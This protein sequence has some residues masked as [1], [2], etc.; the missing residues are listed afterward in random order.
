MKYDTPMSLQAIPVVRLATLLVV[1]TLSLPA[2]F[3]A[4]E[5]TCL[6][7]SGGAARGA[8]HVGVLEALEQL[9]VPVDCIVGTSM[10]AI[11]GGLYASGMT[12]AEIR[13]ELLSADWSDLFNDR[14]ARETIPFRRK[15]ND[16]L[17]LF[18]FEFGVNRSGLVFPSGLIA[19]QKLDFLLK[20]LTIHT[21]GVESFD[22]LPIR[23]R[24]VATSLV[25]GRMVVLDHGSLADALRASMSVPGV[26]SPIEIEGEFL[27]DGG[28]ARNLPV[29]VART[30]GADRVIA[31]DISTPVDPRRRPESAL[32]VVSR[33]TNMLM[34]QNME[35]QRR[36]IGEGDILIRP[37]LPG[38]GRSDFQRAGE[39][40]DLGRQAVLNLKEELAAFQVGSEP[41]E[42]WR[43]S[44]RDRARAGE[45]PLH[46]EVVL[47]E[48][49][50]RIDPRR[51]LSRV[52]TRPGKTVDLD[53][54]RQ[55]LSR[56]FELGDFERV[57]FRMEQG[58][59]G[60]RLILEAL[61]K[62]WGPNFVRFGLEL[63]A[64]FR[65]EGEFAALAEWTKFGMNRLG[66][67]WRTLLAIGEENRLFT[68]FYQPLDWNGR[69]FVVPALQ[70][71]REREDLFNQDGT[72]SRFLVDSFRGGIDVG[73][74]FS[75]YGEL[76]AGVMRGRLS[77]DLDTGGVLETAGR[78]DIG[79]YT[80][81]LTLDQ[82]DNANFPRHG[83]FFRSDLFLSRDSL[84]ADQAYEKLFTTVA[85][86]IS[87]G[88]NT[89][90]GRLAYGANLGSSLPSYDEFTLGGFLNL[91]GL[92]PDSL[93]GQTMAM[94][95]LFLYRRIMEMPQPL[96]RGVYL[97]GSLEAGNVWQSDVT[98]SLGDLRPAAALYVGAD[99]VFGPI[100]FGYG[101]ADSGEG[102]FYLFLGRPF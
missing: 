40:A 8:A 86:A 1:A 69:W 33:T 91:S 6:V 48:G 30:L 10:G 11:I 78:Q 7:L 43:S 87:S 66:G 58:A 29:D 81:R 72:I 90:I 9:Q 32:D 99:T 37:E 38:V 77:T 100:F 89:V 93:R 16:H 31:V 34:E 46:P 84:G 52:H 35:I 82:L 97:G 59:E 54:L 96:G 44:K 56:V 62:S 88:R 71:S 47:V 25:D 79:G 70:W 20:T 75:R 42:A 13:T 17:P 57:D 85:L 64:D 92:S 61:E 28:I 4:E 18:E 68:E 51:V 49:L 101:R 22:Q 60:D 36:S 80:A 45:R 65:G 102:S 19:G 26:L 94:A 2:V 67:E 76:R 55:D 63:Q 95:Q 74:Q 12:P 3:P 21:T 41:Y 14:P 5:T 24:A 27:V 98:P 39:V 23:F 83:Y 50:N 53:L 15:Q 73:F